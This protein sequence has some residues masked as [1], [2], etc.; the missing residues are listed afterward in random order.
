MRNQV[1]LV[2]EPALAANID[3]L[4][5]GTTSKHD[6]LRYF[7]LPDFEVNG[8]NV[9]IHR[10]SPMARLRTQLDG[11][12]TEAKRQSEQ[13]WGPKPQVNFDPDEWIKSH[14]YSSIND[15]HVVFLYVELDSQWRQVMPP[16]IAPFVLFMVVRAEDT[17]RRNRLFLW[18]NKKTELVDDFA[19]REEFRVER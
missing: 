17:V 5:K 1:R 12:V 10:G 9:T 19:Y 14:P 13:S 7:G 11:R 18:I 8:S 3:K 15:D 4:V 2:H 6:V 16:P